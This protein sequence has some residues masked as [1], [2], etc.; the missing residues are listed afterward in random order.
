M[1][2]NIHINTIWQANRQW[3]QWHGEKKQT[4]YYTMV[5]Q[6]YNPL[7]MFRALLCPSSGARDY[8]DGYGMWHETLCL[9]LV[10]GLGWNCRL[11]VLVEGCCLTSQSSNIPLLRHI[12]YSS[13]PD[14]QPATNKVSRATCC[15]HLYSLELLKMNI[16]VP[17]TW[18]A[19]NKFDKPLRSI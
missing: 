15:N 17:E 8:T 10:V 12:A 14:Q 4:R 13:T 3:L 1:Y 18:W 2:F 16:I 6:T 9:W 11:C 19:D 7:T 5:Y